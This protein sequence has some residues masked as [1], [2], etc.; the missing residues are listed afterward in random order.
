MASLKQGPE[1]TQCHSSSFF[2][3]IKAHNKASSDSKGGV[4]ASIARCKELKSTL[5]IFIMVHTCPVVLFFRI[6]HNYLVFYIL[7]VQK[8]HLLTSLFFFKLSQT[9]IISISVLFYFFSGEFLC[10]HLAGPSLPHLSLHYLF[11][12]FVCFVVLGPQPTGYG[13]SQARGQIEAV[14]TGL[15]QSH[16]NARSKQ[17]LR[18]TP[19]LTAKLDP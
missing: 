9:H 3:S 18:P 14:A 6:I 8:H 12:L 17:H 10:Y 16:S 1:F 7:F 2:L 4:S 13:G 5:A 15:R 11:C 19:Q